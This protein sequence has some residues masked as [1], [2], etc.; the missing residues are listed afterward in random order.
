MADENTGRKKVENWYADAQRVIADKDKQLEEAKVA[1]TQEQNSHLETQKEKESL[2]KQLTETQD[3]YNAEAATRG[4]FENLSNQ[5]KDKLD[6]DR[7]RFEQE[8]CDYL[9]RIKDLEAALK[10][11]EERIHEHNLIDEDLANQLAKVKSQ[12]DA[13][14]QR[15][16]QES[17]LNFDNSVSIL[18]MTF[19]LIA[20]VLKLPKFVFIH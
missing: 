12:C 15:Y 4:H 14:L 16:K 11:A 6:F 1:I 8:I 13:D 9:N 2:Q 17:Q 19:C 3:L 5:L 18:S 7:Q 10:A 20:I